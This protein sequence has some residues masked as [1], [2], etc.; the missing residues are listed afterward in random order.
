MKKIYLLCIIASM[1]ASCTKISDEK[2][3][4]QDATYEVAIEGYINQ[5]FKVQGSCTK[6]FAHYSDLSSSGF[7]NTKALSIQGADDQFRVITLALYFN[8]L[9]LDGIF[10]LGLDN[11][12]LTYP[13]WASYAPDGLNAPTTAYITDEKNTGTCIITEYNKTNQTVSGIFDFSGQEYSDGAILAGAT[14][15]FSGSFSDVPINDITDLNNPK[16]VCYGTQ[17]NPLGQEGNNGTGQTSTI[18]FTNPAYTPIDITFNGHTKTAPVGGNAVFSGSANSSGTG[19]A[20]TSGKTTSGTQVGLLLTWNNF[21]MTFPAA[22]TNLNSPLNVGSEFFFL[23]MKNS[24]SYSLQKVYVNY[25]LQAQSVDNITIPNDGA[26]YNLGYYKAYTNSNVR[27]ESDNF[28][29]SFNSLNLA[30]MKNQSTI[31]IAY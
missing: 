17:G 5:Q 24:S 14:A 19:T 4:K 10:H 21:T 2:K 31:L 8:S 15:H 9:P 22:G 28:S 26:V 18:T 27:A 13:G 12:D 25:G 7:A 1:I 11:A 29:W 23:K 16:G 20:S 3:K 6:V 30:F